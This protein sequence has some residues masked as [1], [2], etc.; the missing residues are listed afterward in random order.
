L[1]WW[2]SHYR[3][4]VNFKLNLISF[5]HFHFISFFS[6]FVELMYLFVNDERG[7]CFFYLGYRQKNI[8]IS[9]I[10]C[11]CSSIVTTLAV[12]SRPRQGH[13]KVQAKSEPG[14]HI[15]CFRECKRVQGN[16][17]HIPKWAPILGVRV[18]MDSRIFRGQL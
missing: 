12:G 10:L 4:K 8:K 11:L 13:V 5:F 16:E 7:F 1:F 2:N 15:S 6:L 9:R 14:N 18:P 17:P 3:T